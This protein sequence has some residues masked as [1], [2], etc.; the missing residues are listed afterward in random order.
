M[1]REITSRLRL[2]ILAVCLPA[3]SA[4][5]AHA[6]LQLSVVSGRVLGPDGVPVPSVQIALSDPLGQRVAS[7]TSDDA[8]RFRLRGVAAGV[9]HLEATS[10]PLRSQV[11]R[12]TLGKGLAVEVDLRLSPHQT[13]SVTVAADADAGGSSSGTTL[14]GEAVRRAPAALRHNALRVAV[15]TTPGWTSE[16]NG[17][18]H[19]RGVDD[20]LL[21]V[22]DGV[23]VYERLDPQ[24]GVGLDPAAL[25]SVRILSGFVPPEFGLRSGGV[26]EV[27]SRGAAVDSWA[28]AI[29]AGGGTYRSQAISALAQGPLGRNASVTASVGGERAR[30]YL[31][32][33]S[34]DNLHNEGF[35][36][37]GEAELVWAPGADL[38]TLR[39]GH[40]RSEFDVPNDEGQEEA[41]QDQRQELGQAF[42]TAT[43]QRTWSNSTVSQ[44]ALFG[45]FTNGQL[46]GSAF[47]TPVSPAADREQDRWGMLAAATHERGGHRLKGGIEVSQVRLDESFRFFVVDR[48]A[49]EEAGLSDAALEHDADN[50][51]EFS[52]RVRRPIYSFYVQDSWRPLDR[53]TVDVGVRYDHSRL[54]LSEDQWSPRLGVSYRWGRATLRASVNRFFQPPQTE[55]LLLSSSPQAQALS[56][57]VDELGAGGAEVRAERQTA[58]EFGC[59]LWLGPLRA[60][61]AVWQRRIRNQ[62]DPNVFFGTTVIFPNAVDRGDARGFDVRLELPRRRGVSGFVTY[63]L[64]KI[65]QYGPINGGLF[66]E[67]EIIDIGPGTKFTPDHDQ[68]HAL[69]AEVGYEAD[70]VGFWGAAAVRYRSGTPL[71]VE[72]NELDELGQRPG[73]DLVD[74]ESGRVKPYTVIDVQAGQRLVRRPGVELSAQAAVLNLTDARYAFNFGN[75]FSGTHFGAPRTFRLDLKLAIR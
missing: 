73:A 8:G 20:G 15:S 62:G 75:P 6:Q 57:F 71:E 29:N 48:E 22:L 30:R 35:A 50:P 41:G 5:A 11:Q 27:R 16:D 72:E 42:G 32:P 55:N 14:A 9:Y 46:L 19:Y 51:F 60:D 3:I 52:G 39:G 58:L 34:L 7:V 33:V 43:W 4:P 61:A 66:L 69:S 40:H 68:R 59:E 26:I 70:Q 23:P 18:V 13:E 64:A 56:P 25:E 67:D 21:L 2:G 49:G 10:P 37:G 63:T 12:L 38:L 1:L 47:D 54:L 24:F 36:R 28:G 17:L 53:L 31:D 45:R 44:L 74:F 65:D